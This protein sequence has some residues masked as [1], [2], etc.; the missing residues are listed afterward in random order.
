[1]KYTVLLFSLFFNVLCGGG[2]SSQT[3]VL[4]KNGYVEISTIKPGDY[5]LTS[6]NNDTIVE[7]EVIAT[8]RHIK[9]IDMFALPLMMKL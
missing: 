4:M 9:L 8:Y 7:E 2:F 6:D 3:V 1:M 5:V